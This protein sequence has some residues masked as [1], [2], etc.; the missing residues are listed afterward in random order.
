[1]TCRWCG[2]DGV[3]FSV[4]TRIRQALRLDV[5]PRLNLDRDA[6]REFCWTVGTP[7]DGRFCVPLARA[8]AQ[9]RAYGHDLLRDYPTVTICLRCYGHGEK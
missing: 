6:H 5:R 9:W 8:I 3:A 2:G 7:Q 1:M 4:P